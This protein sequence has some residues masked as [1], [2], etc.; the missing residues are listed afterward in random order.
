[1]LK[2]KVD[3]KQINKVLNNTVS[4]SYGFLEGTEIN[5]ILFNQKLGLFIESALKKYIDSKARLN[6][7]QLHHVYE[8]GMTGSPSGRLFDFSVKASKRIITINGKFLKSSSIP[9]GGNEPFVDKANVMENKI[10]VTVSPKNSKVLVFE[11]DGE[12]IFTTNSVYIANPGGDAVAE[13]FGKVCEEFFNV[14]L[15]SGLFTS[16]GIFKKLSNPKEFENW[17]PEGAKTGKS[18]GIKAGK[19]YMDIPDG[20]IVQ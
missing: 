7:E 17:F 12:T 18:S 9:P 8:W 10:S 11:D 6:P 5:Q 15:T 14:Y 4:Y 3:S 13:G 20:L 19:K 16:S 1:M 2:L